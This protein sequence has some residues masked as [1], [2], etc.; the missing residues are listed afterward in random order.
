MSGMEKRKAHY[1]LTVVKRL[2]KDGQVEF[3]MTA[4]AGGAAIG[5]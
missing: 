2:I 5:F 4:L 3:T 1:A